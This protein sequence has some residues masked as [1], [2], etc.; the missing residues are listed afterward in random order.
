MDSTQSHRIEFDFKNSV[1]K[2]YAELEFSF[3]SIDLSKI[4]YNFVRDIDKM[5]DDTIEGIPTIL[6]ILDKEGTGIKFIYHIDT[7]KFPIGTLYC[8]FWYKNNMSFSTKSVSTIDDLS[9]SQ[10]RIYKVEKYENRLVDWCSGDKLK[11]L[12]LV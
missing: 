3:Y 6:G 11:E 7:S 5:S 9:L 8:M 4:K 10:I 12:D 2:I 1:Y